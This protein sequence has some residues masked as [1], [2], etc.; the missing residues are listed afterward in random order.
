MDPLYK[1]ALCTGWALVILGLVALAAI[2]IVFA[3]L[4]RKQDFG[5][6]AD[7]GRAAA[8]CLYAGLTILGIA[9]LGATVESVARGLRR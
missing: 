9:A 3:F 2:A 1:V 7:L 5:V 8:L 4:G 6:E